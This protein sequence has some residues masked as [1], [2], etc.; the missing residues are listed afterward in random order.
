MNLYK[1]TKLY[2]IVYDFLNIYSKVCKQRCLILENKLF[3]LSIFPFSFCPLLRDVKKK[4]K[5]M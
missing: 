4:G 2:Q 1:L 5:E 3:A